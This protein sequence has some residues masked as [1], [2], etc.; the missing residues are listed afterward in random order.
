MEEF[1]NFKSESQ[2]PYIKEEIEKVEIKSL[3]EGKLHELNNS[4]QEKVYVLHEQWIKIFNE[5]NKLKE[6]DE[7]NPNIKK[8]KNSMNLINQE[9]KNISNI[10]N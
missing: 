3:E 10:L 9:I 7:N 5:F 4:F 2:D 6:V 8:L 1:K